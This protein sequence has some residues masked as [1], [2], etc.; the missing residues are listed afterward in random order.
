MINMNVTRLLAL[1][2][3]LISLTSIYADT[4]SGK[5]KPG[6]KRV[7]HVNEVLQKTSHDHSVS[8]PDGKVQVSLALRHGAPSWSVVFDGKK[9][10]LPAPIGIQPKGKPYKKWTQVGFV[11]SSCDQ[12]WKP[13]WGKCSLIRNYYQQ[14]TWK[15]QESSGQKRKLNITLRV[16]NNAAALRYE[17][18][19]TGK[20]TYSVDLTT[21]A[22]NADYTCWSANGEHSNHGPVPLSKWRGH[23]LPLTV[24]IAPDCY[25]AI[26]E[27]AIDTFANIGLRRTATTKFR[28]KLPVSAVTLPAVTPWRTL[29]LG[30]NPGELLTNN[31]LVNLNP[32]PTQ[33][34]S[35]VK[36]GVSL[37]DWRQWGAKTEDGFV[38]G[39]DMSSWKR[40]IDFASKNKIPYLLLDATWYG[41]EFDPNEDPTTS[42]D[43][44]V[45]QPDPHKAK[46][47]RKPA[48]SNWKH[49][50][51]I[52]ELIRYAKSKNVA[53]ILYLNDAAQRKHDIEHTLA[54]Y[55]KWGAAGIKYGFMRG[56]VQYKVLKT[57]R[58][59][60]L[61][62]KYHLLCNFHDGPI[63]PSG[64]RRTY[65][66]YI[67]REFCHAQSDGRRTFSPKT[68]CT[69]V[70]TNMLTGPIDMDNGLF[71]INGSKQNRP[72]I[73]A[74]LYSTVTAETARTLI[75]FSG[76]TVI[77]DTPEAYAKK[78]D[79]F[80]FIASL[81]MTWDETR[82]LNASIGHYIT[83]ARRSGDD[84]FIASCC[85]AK[86][87]TL[88]INFDFLKP[89]IV[90]KATLYEDAPTAHFKTNRETYRIRSIKVKKGD[91]INVKLAPG[92]GNCIHLTPGGEF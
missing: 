31:T 26:V 56:A 29:L 90:Y 19:D 37:W 28:A 76:L 9:I 39:L 75:T 13:T 24:K 71:D 77:P 6:I 16:F 23:Q 74:E 2:F 82:I 49:P 52:P 50:I 5:K 79:L 63:P 70:F 48:P 3:F 85:D 10:L 35:W 59:V 21:F 86:G 87:V 30:R 51:D 12:S 69:T 33:D 22:F 53:I 20:A 81:P 91:E 38:Y 18:P 34:F 57:R 92:G 14:A 68:F 8:S 43:H 88:P 54:T 80:R 64:E 42:R 25:V 17:I 45:I 78:A 41:L 72:K 62:A 89:G 67:T 27:A 15:L 4:T 32:P 83:T 47:I 65:P 11:T 40:Q 73:F 84:W 55:Q 36:P 58:I 46:L 7:A 60:Q 61:C 66:N 1:L 44:L